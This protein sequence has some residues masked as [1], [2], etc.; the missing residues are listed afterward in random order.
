MGGRAAEEIALN[1]RTT[2]AGND[3]ERASELARKMVC[4]YG[5]SQNMGPMTFGKKEEQIFLGRE[6]SQHRDYSE[7]TAQKIDEEVRDIVTGAYEKASQLIKDNLDILH[8]MAND[9]LEKETLDSSD[10]DEI[11]N[12]GKKPVPAETDVKTS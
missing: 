8:S 11:M 2:G 12:S 5:M 10:I 9:L 7:Q 1:M 3:I 4:D 6:I